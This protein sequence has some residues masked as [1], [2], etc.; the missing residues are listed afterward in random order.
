MVDLVLL[1]LVLHIKVFFLYRLSWLFARDVV[2]GICGDKDIAF[3]D[4]GEGFGCALHVAPFV[5]AEINYA[6]PLVGFIDL[7]VIADECD[8]GSRIFMFLPI[9]V[10]VL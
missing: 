3:C 9:T 7:E 1:I 8:G 4:I 6:G 5:G 10:E 2:D